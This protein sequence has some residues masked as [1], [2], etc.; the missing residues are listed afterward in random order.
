MNVKCDRECSGEWRAEDKT[1]E[2]R[3]AAVA[4]F[5]AGH[6]VLLDHVVEDQAVGLKR[7]RAGRM[8]A[9]VAALFRDEA[10]L[11]DPWWGDVLLT[12]W[13]L[14]EESAPLVA[15]LATRRRDAASARSSWIQ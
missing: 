5:C 13:A 6:R 1:R 11:E 2:V 10:K 14:A 7:M 12:A 9:G 3:A 4:P 15:A 8:H